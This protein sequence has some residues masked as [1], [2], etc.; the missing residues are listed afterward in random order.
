MARAV[1]LTSLILSV[2]RRANIENQTAFFP[3]AEITEYLNAGLSALY[4]LLVQ[5]GAQPWYRNSY[6]IATT[7]NQTSY[8]LP[9][10][11][12]ELQ[13]VDIQLG[14]GGIPTITAKPYMEWERNRYK[15][16][17]GWM[18][19]TPVYYRLQAN[20]INFL[21]TPNSAFNVV[22]NYYPIF[23]PLVAGSDTFDG[24]NGWEEFAIWKATAD[25][26]AKLEEDP[27]FAM[28]S[29]STLERKIQSMSEQRDTGYSE[30]MTETDETGWPD[31]EVR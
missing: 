26:K 8:D 28:A 16:Y 2:R 6:S 3:D 17:P 11:F 18:Q 9:A 10:D 5:A 20:K 29:M 12:Y 27:S 22:L 14:V 25:C 13:S 23:T 21:P 24:V 1:T 19:G 4:D 31:F 15:Y 30:C 7:G